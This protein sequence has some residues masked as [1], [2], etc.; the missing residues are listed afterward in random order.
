MSAQT[1]TCYGL[2]P[3]TDGSIIIP[4]V[5][6]FHRKHNPEAAAYVFA[7]EDGSNVTTTI[8]HLEF[9]RAADR[10]AHLVRPERRGADK[11]VIGVVAL[12]DTILYHAVLVGIMRAGYVVSVFQL[13]GNNLFI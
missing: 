1:Q 7:H 9:G 11:E 8:T 3:A 4:E 12:S 10:V 5:V 6:D 2:A 13:F